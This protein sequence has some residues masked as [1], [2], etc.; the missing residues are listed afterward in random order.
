MSLPIG[1]ITAIRVQDVSTGQWFEW[2]TP[3]KI[4]NIS[5]TVKVGTGN[6]YIAA[7]ARNIGD[8]DPFAPIA[9]TLYIQ[10]DTGVVLAEKSQ[11]LWNNEAFGLELTTNMPDRPYGITIIMYP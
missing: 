5:P 11:I 7:W 6:L 10:D 3:G 2:N 9:S 8:N 4:W 1:E